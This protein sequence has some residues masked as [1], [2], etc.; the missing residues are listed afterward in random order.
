M[1]TGWQVIDGKT[2]YFK[3]TEGVCDPTEGAAITG[4]KIIDGSEYYFDKRVDHG[5]MV[6]NQNVNSKYYGAD[7]KRDK[8]KEYHKDINDK[9]YSANIDGTIYTHNCPVDVFVLDSA[10]KCV[11]S[12]VGNVEHDN[13][14]NDNV[15]VWLDENLQKRVF[16]PKD[17]DYKLRIV[18]TDEGEFNYTV[19]DYYAQN[20]ECG[21]TAYFQNLTINSMDELYSMDIKQEIHKYHL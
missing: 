13:D 21:E 16:T 12:I 2:H 15:F 7:G 8:S 4:E 11:A 10:S 14:V 1:L 17:A 9:V 6:T 20:K 18:A 3:V 19:S 5:A